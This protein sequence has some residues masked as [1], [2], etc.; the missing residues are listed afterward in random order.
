M[1][2]KNK[3]IRSIQAKLDQWGVVLIGVVLVIIVMQYIF[4]D[5]ITGTILKSCLFIIVLYNVSI[6][7]E[8]TEGFNFKRIWHN[9]FRIM[10]MILGF[11][12]II[13]SILL[14]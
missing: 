10:G 5:F 13:I 7:A 2:T 1:A 11:A 3:K 12:T 9:I 8:I 6:F 4:Q 14:F